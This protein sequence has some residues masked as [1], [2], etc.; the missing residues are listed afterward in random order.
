LL[1]EVA[2]AV[3][4]YAIPAS[5]LDELLDGVARD[6]RPVAPHNWAEL[7]RYCQGVASSVGEMCTYIFGVNGDALA[8]VQAR[9]HARTLGVAMQL[10]NILRDVGEDAANG[11]CYL[12][13]SDLAAHGLTRGDVLLARVSG[14]AQWRALMQFEIARA[15]ALYETAAPGIQH[16]APDAR[17]CASACAIGY[18]GILDV[19]ERI[20]YDTFRRRAR[21]SALGRA[22]VFWSAWRS[23]ARE[24]VWRKAI[25]S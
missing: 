22:A 15:R 7:E 23:P 9:R 3:R 25:V 4:Q 11:R 21:L 8:R 2:R 12:P 16:L 1:S 18:A 6:C 10:T 14:T 5:L 13:D 24:R 17:R 20:D 19:I